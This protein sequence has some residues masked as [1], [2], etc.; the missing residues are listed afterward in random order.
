M[1]PFSFCARALKE[2]TRDIATIL[3]EI[4]GLAEDV[5]SSVVEQGFGFRSVSVMAVMEDLTLRSRSKTFERPRTSLEIV[6]K[7]WK[8]F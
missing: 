2:N 8:S 6:R 7:L 3:K 1:K 5:H 4:I